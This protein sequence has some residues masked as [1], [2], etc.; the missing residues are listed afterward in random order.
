MQDLCQ[1]IGYQFK[2]T[3]L[4][5]MALTHS[6]Y[7]NENHKNPLS[8]YERLE[9][10]GDSVLQII[11][12][13][14][15]YKGYPHLPEGKLSKARASL[16]CE[17]ALHVSALEMNL[18]AYL[19]LSKGEEHCGGRERVSIL[20]D[21]V[22]AIIGAIYLDAGLL[23]ASAFIY[24]FILRDADSKMRFKDY[25]TLLQEYAQ[26]YGDTLCYELVKEEGP[27]HDKTFETRVVYNGEVV[28]EGIGKSKKAAEQNAAQSALRK[29]NQIK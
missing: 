1:I 14:F 7:T 8:S 25:K 20:A 27:D 9:F 22:E 3:S 24:R 11:S 21:V 4:L 29:F 17:S 23:E 19:R 18:G 16:V 6:S 5:E 15:L 2:D 26:K 10:L 12:S 28:G 13:D